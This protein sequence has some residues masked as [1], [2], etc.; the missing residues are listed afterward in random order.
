MHPAWWCLCL[1]CVYRVRW[2]QQAHRERQGIV[3]SQE[4]LVRMDNQESQEEQDHRDL[5]ERVEM[6]DQ[7]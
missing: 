2:V 5:R 1:L 7:K 4:Q 6:T 3:G